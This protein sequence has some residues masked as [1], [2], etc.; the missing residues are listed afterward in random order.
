MSLRKTG[1]AHHHTRD[2]V[3]RYVEDALSIV[4]AVELDGELRPLAF[5]KALDLLATKQIMY[6]QI[7]GGILDGLGA[8]G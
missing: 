3:Q 6:E 8:R 5:A 1:E 4:E 7:A 2:E